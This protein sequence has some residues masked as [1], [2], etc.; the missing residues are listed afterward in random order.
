MATRYSV[1][2]DDDLAE[3]VESLAREYD[4]TEG[5]VIRQLLDVGIEHIE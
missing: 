1:V 2:C 3:Q 5:E 4:L